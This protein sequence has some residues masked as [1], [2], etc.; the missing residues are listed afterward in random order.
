MDSIGMIGMEYVTT[1]SK[2]DKS[3]SGVYPA[4]NSGNNPKKLATFLRYGVR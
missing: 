1:A 4:L 3:D 2:A